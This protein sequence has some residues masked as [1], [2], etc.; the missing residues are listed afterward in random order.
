MTLTNDASKK[1]AELS[2]EA[3]RALLAQLLR[4]KAKVKEPPVGAAGAESAPG[5]GSA[6]GTTIGASPM[7]TAAPVPTSTGPAWLPISHNQKALWFLYRLAPESAAYNLLYAA[8]IRSHLDVP[9]LQRAL[10]VLANRYPLLTSTYTL[11]NGEPVQHLRP[12]QAFPLEQ[13]DAYSR[14]LDDLRLLLQEESNRPIDLTKGP[15]LRLQLYRRTDDD[16]IL[17]FI[18]HHIAADFWALDLLV[19]ELYLLYAVEKTG[20][21][22]DHEWLPEPG[23]QNADY[24]RWQQSM[25]QG[26]E[27]DQHWHYWQ[28]ELAGD[29][30]VLN[31]PTDRPRPPVQTYKGASYGFSLSPDLTKKLRTVANEEK[32]TLFTLMLAAYQTLLYRYT[33]Q[34]DILVGTPALGRTRSELERVIGYLVNPVIVRARMAQNLTFKELLNQTKRG[35]FSALEHQDFPFPLLVERLQ[36]RRDPSYSPI[37]QTLFIWDRPRTR[38]EQDLAR[39]GQNGR[40]QAQPLRVETSNGQGQAQPL[41]AE[42][43]T[44]AQRI[45]EAGLVFE[46]FIYG[47]QGAPFDLTL[48]IFEIEGALTGEIHYNVDL[49]DAPTLSR[50][51][52][53]FLTLLGGIAANPGQYLLELPLL[54]ESERNKLLIEWNA[55]RSPYP[56]TAALHQLIEAQVEKTPE[57]TALIF[58]DQRRIYRELNSE[59]NQLAHR[60]QHAGIKPDTLVGVCMERSLEMVVSLLAVLKA[61]GAYVPLD[62]T[63]PQERLAYMIQDAQV[64]V[65]LTQSHLLER[66]PR[67]SVTIMTVDPGWNAEIEG[68]EDNPVSAIEPEH[69]AYMIYTSGSTGKPKGV[70]NTHLGICNR[71]HW[72]Q[73]A[74][75]LTSEDRVLQKTP[76]SFDVSVWEFFWPLL[77]GATLV[78]ARP[79]GHQD[80]AYLANL[81][82][83]Q[84]ITTLHFVPS[85]LQAFLLGTNL[86][87]RCQSLKRVICSGEALSADLQEHFFARF[88]EP[89]E[90]HNLY[91]PTEAAIDVTAWQCQR[92][93]KRVGTDLIP[94]GYPIA[95]TQIYILN[96]VGQPTPIGVPGELHI[97]GVGVARGYHNRPELTAEKFVRDPFVGNGSAQGTIPTV[98]FK[99][100]DL[101]RYRSDGAIEFLGRIDHQVKIRGFR[102]ELG[103]I[104]AVL[105]EHPAIKE[106]VVIAREDMFGN[107]R[108]VAYLVANRDA[109]HPSIEDLRIY[110][111]EKLPAYMIPAIFMYLEALPLSPNG[112]VDRKALPTPDNARPELESA[113]VPARTPTE[114]RLAAIWAE[115]LQL[116]KVGIHDNYFDLGGASLQS[117]D[118]ISKATE[119]GVAFELEMIFEFQT[120]E[121]LAAAIDA[122]AAQK[123]TAGTGKE[124]APSLQVPTQPAP[125]QETQEVQKT[126]LGNM[127]I[128]SLGS[129]LPPKIVASEEIIQ[130][131]VRPIRFP[132]ARLT[133]IK[134]RRMAGETEFSLDIAKKAVAD[135]FANSR[136]NP[137]DIDLIICGSISRC[138]KPLKTWFEPTNSV[139]VQRHFGMHNALAFD[140]TNACTGL[141]TCMYIAESFL[142]TGLIRRALVFS[143]EY[144]SHLV[145]T[146]QKEIESYMD[147]RLACLTIG[148]AGAALILEMRPDKKLGFHEFEMYT[149][150]AYSEACIAK[151]TYY[152]HGGAIMYT[153]AV[154]V[155]TVNMKQATAH[156]GYIIERA[157]WSPNDFQ[158]ILVHQTSHTTI[159]DVARAFNKY[160]GAEVCNQDTVINNIAERGNT[161]TTAHMIA[162]MDSIQNNTIQNG[163]NIIFGITGSGATIGTALYTFDDLPERIRRREAGTYTPEKVVPQQRSFIARLPQNR[164]VRIESV[165]T[166]PTDT[167]TPKE[168]L[169]LIR[170]AVENCLTTSAYEKNETD[171][172]IY[173]GTYRDEFISEPAIA[174]LVAGHLEINPDIDVP[175]Q[176]KTFAL[177]LLNGG[178]ATLNACY[179]ATAMILTQRANNALIV[180]SEV[181]NNKDKLPADLYN[182]EEAGSALFLDVSPD[183]K[184]G[185][186]NFVF[187]QFTDYIEALTAHTTV[188]NGGKTYLDIDRDPHLERYYRQCIKETVQELLTREQLELSQIKVILPPQISSNFITELSKDLEVRRDRLVDVQAQ[189][190]LHTS[191]L[192]YALEHVRELQLAQAGDIGLIISVGSGIQ[193][194]CATYYF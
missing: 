145:Q 182:V 144:I 113:F 21:G 42:K 177:D 98:L 153:D 9:A 49:F 47:Q 20:P 121:E 100:A 26:Q 62:P 2:P 162:L 70:M 176:K 106:V 69:L 37:Y 111:K 150:G 61:G 71:L 33:N 28:N 187:K 140:V 77:T 109:M 54:P 175:Q 75:Q 165:G 160:Y 105:S 81:I 108:L 102:I 131:C 3:K 24:V 60:L 115:V 46:P 119:S 18:V 170:V 74:Y 80:P 64:P 110:L 34:E 88:P 15:V 14:S 114:Q 116:E 159:K 79:G 94:I 166:V 78:V 4:E 12:N 5:I 7:A 59:A 50:M 134:N 186:G 38:K 13:I 55:T 1:L 99:T 86:E 32:V 72:M 56:D 124:Q 35:V 104:E 90:L 68:Q 125:F 179:T 40:G 172:L 11:Q 43:G 10:G 95:N 152:E 29:L 181:E 171:L 97:G 126:D 82:E 136:Y 83:A 48:T 167:Q 31:L 36:P 30:P 133:G 17:G 51:A 6:L 76:F 66:L 41:R 132:L 142:K 138:H 87:Q 146:T 135:C 103:E 147:S 23:F 85:M 129:Y 117:L 8:R 101:A 173:S 45:A 189:H 194:G 107:K 91:G 130:N 192:A 169:A 19:D 52:E 188:R 53:H 164:R 122:R 92:N 96:P 89:V 39:L 190:D 127:V 57:Q 112:K 44:L 174:A 183:G 184:S 163:E 128:E 123:T 84:R 178:V 63:Y 156:A 67:D 58:A 143:G 155:S 185:F 22:Q 149:L 73:Q 158:H 27:G 120:I 93:D 151:T 161:A 157:K 191:S 180:A 139:Q 25:L 168:T 137:E 141:F 193:V 154:Q 16:Y 118:I 148:D 65:L